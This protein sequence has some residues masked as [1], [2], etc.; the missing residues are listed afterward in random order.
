VTS[1]GTY[2][3]TD[4]FRV[5]VEGGKVK[6]WKN[7]VLRYQSA[8]T[9][10]YP[11]LLD[12]SIDTTAGAV[13]DALIAGEVLVNAWPTL[14][15][16]DVA[17]TSATAVSVSG[18]SITRNIPGSQLLWNA[19]AVST[20]AIGSG[21]GYVEFQASPA[22]GAISAGLGNGNSGLSFTDIE[23]GVFFWTNGSAYVYES[24]QYVTSLGTYTTTDR[25][26]VGVEGGKVKYWKNGTMLFQSAKTP[27]Y[28][29]L[30]DTSIDTT[31]GAVNNAT[32]AGVDLQ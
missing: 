5:G 28:P 26:R 27:A 13:S 1:L 10:S 19:G 31:N 30:L 14:T 9:P 6:Y 8:K 21:D 3:T 29:L 4:R 23:Y 22:P 17:W 25:F 16:E 11:L 24:G 15:V 18:S 12:T 32:I 20:R 7:G 2:T